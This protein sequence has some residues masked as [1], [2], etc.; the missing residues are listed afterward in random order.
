[1][2][3]PQNYQDT[4]KAKAFFYLSLAVC[5]YWALANSTL[6]RDTN[7]QVIH[8]LVWIFFF[9]ALFVL[10]IIAMVFLVKKGFSFK[11]FYFYSAALLI[12]TQVVLRLM[13]KFR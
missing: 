4:P 11:S 6:V 2:D 8:E 7:F 9:P 1:M 12:L 10:P 5:A 13:D 3:S